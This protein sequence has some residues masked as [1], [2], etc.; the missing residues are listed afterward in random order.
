MPRAFFLLIV[1]TFKENAQ[2]RQKTI[3]LIE[4]KKTKWML[5]QAFEY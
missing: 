1:D 5:E 4:Y 3:K 2:T